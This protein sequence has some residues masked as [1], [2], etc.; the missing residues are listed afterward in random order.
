MAS[1][2][3]AGTTRVMPRSPLTEVVRARVT[4]TT[5]TEVSTEATRER[6]TESDMV[7]VLLEEALAARARRPG[8]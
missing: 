5:K 8:R 3:M 2:P 7:R 6:R 4:T 1:R